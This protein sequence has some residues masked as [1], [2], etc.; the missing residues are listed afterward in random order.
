MMERRGERL[1]LKPASR[2][3]LDFYAASILQLFDADAETIGA[4]PA[5]KPENLKR[6]RHKITK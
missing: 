6:K 1:V 2:P 3:I 5:E 4:N